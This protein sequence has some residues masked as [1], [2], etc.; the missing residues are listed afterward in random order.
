MTQT[1]ARNT[2]A[3]YASDR[4][5]RLLV[6]AVFVGALTVA[7]LHSSMQGLLRYMPLEAFCMVGFFLGSGLWVALSAVM[8]AMA[9]G[10]RL[11]AAQKTLVGDALWNNAARRV[12][13]DAME[14]A[15]APEM[16]TVG[17]LRRAARAHVFEENLHVSIDE[18]L[19]LLRLNRDIQNQFA[20][21]LT[22][23]S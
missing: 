14:D 7:F 23:Q 5:W 15:G 19:R 21:Y 4:K 6:E 18:Q 13:E 9:S 22:A 17:H 12:L 16:L 20:P 8:D 2:I 3:F 1:A 10:N 11:D